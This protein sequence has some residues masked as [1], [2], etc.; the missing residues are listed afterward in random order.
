MSIKR[1][2]E[3]IEKCEVLCANCHLIHHY[4][5]RQTLAIDLYEEESMYQELLNEEEYEEQ[6]A[7][8]EELPV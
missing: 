1:I 2:L 3:E 5:E 4:E 7:E 8:M 6:F